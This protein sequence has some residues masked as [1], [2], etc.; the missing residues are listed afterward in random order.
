[1]RSIKIENRSI[2]EKTDPYIIAEAGVNY[3][4]IAESK[5]IPL[6]EAAREMVEQAAK[7]GAD[8]IKFQSYKAEKLS[9]RNSPAYWD[10]TKE[11]T[12]SQYE[13]F[14]KYDRFGEDE[15][16][17][18][19]RYSKKMGITFLST[20]FDMES[21]DYLDGL[22][23]AFKVASADITNRPFLEHIAEKKKPMILSTGA[24]NIEEIREAVSWITE[25]SDIDVA[26]LHC[27]LCY[28]TPNEYANLAMINSLSEE[29]P[30]NII[31]YSDH[32]L[33]SEG[34]SILTTAYLLGARIIEK[35]F[36]LD[37]T[38]PGND[39]YH[40]MDPKDLAILR[41]NM[42]FIRTILGNN[43]KKDVV[44]CEKKSRLQAR[45]SLVSKRAIVKGELIRADMLTFK[46]PGTGISPREI[47]KVVGRR[48]ARD[49]PEDEI[50][51][52]DML[53]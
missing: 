39:H 26:L 53:E 48:C 45:R 10:T 33:P 2:T 52:W 9:S 21:A 18:L 38:L 22:M 40:A 32:T 7:G 20:P 13:L 4:E 49:I 41:N 35:H 50:I 47:D 19:A 46:R 14:K 6:M 30:E 25:I 29:F 51:T 23:P 3:Y 37:K 16:R 12:R 1:M 36:T 43:S 42:E 5:K 24:S 34:M 28:P 44:E 8:A 31:G 17:E 11:K 15:Y 27:V